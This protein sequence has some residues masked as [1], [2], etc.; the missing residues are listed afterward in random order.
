V[1]WERYYSTLKR[2]PKRLKKPV[3]FVVEAL[4]SF[5]HRKIKSVLDLGCGAGRHCVYLTKKCFDVIGVDI[6]NSA[7]KMAKQWTRKERLKNVAFLQGPMTQI[8][9]R[10]SHFDAIISISV[11]H[12]AVK[13]DIKKTIAEI[14]RTLKKNGVFLANLASEKDP[15]YG[16][17]KKVE[18]NTF[19]ILEAFKEKRFEELHHYFTEQ[20][21][22]EIVACFAK[23]E[24]ELLE[25]KPHYWKITAIK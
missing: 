20:E 7:L 3:P 23:A 25:D 10:D 16:A 13:N 17:G 8:P 22:F 14:Y 18:N 1:T 19:K 12:H 11:V 5:R 24:I 15:R 9:W 4:P 2:L 6:S 21:V